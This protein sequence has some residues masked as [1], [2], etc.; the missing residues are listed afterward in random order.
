MLTHCLC[1]LRP[2][3]GCPSGNGKRKDGTEYERTLWT[4]D[5]GSPGRADYSTPVSSC[6]HTVCVPYGPGGMIECKGKIRTLTAPLSHNTASISGNWRG[7][8]VRHSAEAKDMAKLSVIRTV[9]ISRMD[10]YQTPVITRR[11]LNRQTATDSAPHTP[12]LRTLI[13]KTTLNIC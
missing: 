12:L 3:R 9:R 1:S 5:Q 8:G 10:N 11:A 6:S 13:K 2:G 7:G 4:S